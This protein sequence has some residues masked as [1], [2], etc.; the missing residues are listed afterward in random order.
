MIYNYDIP[1]EKMLKKLDYCKKWGVQI[2]DCRYRP[3]DSIKDDYNPGKFRSGQTG[4]DYYIH[5][6]GGWTDQKI[7]DFR[8]RVRQ[9]NIWIRYARDKGLGYDKRMEKWSSIHNTFKFFHMG[10]PPQLE[11]I[12]KSP[13]WKRR[14]E[15]MNRIKNYY[16]KQNL[17]T[18]DYSSFTKKRIDEELKKIITNIDLPLFSSR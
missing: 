11:V 6:D 17:N 4:E 8:R 9:L 3:L 10:R 16:K 13:T 18:L 1:Y 2:A 14:L 15:M 12:E 5:T 7:R